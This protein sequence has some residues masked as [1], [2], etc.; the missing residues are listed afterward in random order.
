MKSRSWPHRFSLLAV[1]TLVILQGTVS[2]QAW[3]APKAPAPAK[4][5]KVPANTAK[6]ADSLDL[7]QAGLEQ[8]QELPGIGEAYSKKIVGG[9]PYTSFK[10]LAKL[11][12]P[13]ETLVKIKPLVTIKIVAAK[14][15]KSSAKQETVR[16][17]TPPKKGMVWVNSSTK[18]YHKEGSRWYGKTSEGEWMTEADAIKAGNRAAKNEDAPE[19]KK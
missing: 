9:R 8:L 15:D 11:G 14:A 18:V 4:T 12:I 16:A 2:P 6:P 13:E 17:K 10:D 19:A 3:G 7:N 5:P 1:L